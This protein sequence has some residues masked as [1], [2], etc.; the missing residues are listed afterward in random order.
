MLARAAM[1][2]QRKQFPA[3]TQRR[4]GR[5]LDTKTM[6]RREVFG[7]TPEG[8]P[9][10]LYFLTNQNGVEAAITNYGATLVSLKVPDRAGEFADIVLGYDS[11]DHY[12]ADTRYF[13]GTIGRYANRIANGTFL[14]DGVICTLARN[15][16]ENHL[17]GGN[18]GFNKVVWEASEVSTG[19]ALQLKYLSKDGEEGY[20]GTS[21]SR[22]PTL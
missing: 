12:V 15:R 14:L 21:R 9:I 10:Q 7:T 20:P 17:H 5:R 19:D 8:H 3:K 2:N 22:S 18:R 1:G 11:L 4:K 6:M 16:G 13:G